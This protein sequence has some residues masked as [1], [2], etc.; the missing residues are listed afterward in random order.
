MIF[1]SLLLCL[2]QPIVT[3]TPRTI[4]PTDLHS[5][6]ERLSNTADLTS[7]E[8]EHVS[9]AEGT[10]LGT[11]IEINH[12]SLELSGNRMNKRIPPGTQIVLEFIS[13]NDLNEEMFAVHDRKNCVFSLTNSTLSLKWMHIS[14]NA[15]TEEPRP[16][17]NKSGTP[18]LAIVS[19]SMLTI[20]KSEIEVSS[21]TSAI[22]ISP[23]TLEE[24]CMDSSVLVQKCS[25]SSERGELA[26]VV[27]T[28]ALP[29]VP[30]SVSVSTIGCSFD[31]SRILGQD[32][33]GLSL[34]RPA[35]KNNDEFGSISSS[36]IDCSFVNMSSIGSSRQPHLPHLSQKMLGCVVSR[37]SSH[38]SGSTIRDVN[39]GGS[40]LCSN[41]S[42]SSLLSSPDPD[43]DEEPTI[44]YPNGTTESFVDGRGY[45]FYASSGDKDTSVTISHCPFIGSKYDELDRP[46]TFL[47]YLGTIKI[48]SCSFTDIA[49]ARHF[50]EAMGGAVSI[51][52]TTPG[53][54]PVT[55]RATNFTHIRADQYGGGMCLITYNH[56]TVVDC[57]V[58][59]SDTFETN[60][61]NVAG[62]IVRTFDT[63][64]PAT[65]TNL[66]F[67][68]CLSTSY[69][70]GMQVD[71][72]GPVDL[73]DCLFDDCCTYVIY[74][75]KSGALD[76]RLYG[77]AQTSV[78]R[79]NFT[80]CW[81]PAFAGGM[82][83]Y[84]SCDVVLTDLHFLRCTPDKHWV[85]ITRGG[86]W[87]SSRNEN[88]T[89]TLKDCSFVECE[90]RRV[91]GAAFEMVDFGSCVVTDC[92][93]K[94]CY[95]VAKGAITLNQTRDQPW[96]ISLSR[97]TFINNSFVQ[98]EDSSVS[99]NTA[100]APTAFVDVHLN[101]LDGHPRP[102][103]WTALPVGPLR[104]RLLLS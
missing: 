73:S 54:G 96:S 72:Y 102:T 90:G 5:L 44:T 80:D 49:Y 67:K 100:E 82:C 83:M 52:A 68:T 32:G 4:Y 104:N 39:N 30:G 17:K 28:S 20:S 56:A 74:Y 95:S 103:L 16:Q 71:C 27:E 22:L 101:Y 51:S 36:L 75:T 59:D 81:S 6:L 43:T 97:V 19:D 99:M 45:Y 55:V 94:D 46:L 24:S 7:N 29:H 34:T 42:F 92:L 26:G 62:L 88:L 63:I 23:S 53:C 61:V 98:T 78:T 33:I 1:L 77:N 18:R 85:P 21:W 65:L 8:I 9:L 58:E 37:T 10:Y 31:S 50:H 14:L 76:L 84:A 40:L 60:D 93:V 12:R 66:K 86:M 69:T 64:Y 25:I 11:N 70:G 87:A 89:I 3:I 79:L 41:S 15:R 91:G 57:S 2:F 35:R 38:L 48:L 13:E 47:N